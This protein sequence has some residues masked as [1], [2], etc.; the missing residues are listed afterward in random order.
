[1]FSFSLSGY[2]GVCYDRT[3]VTFNTMEDLK[4]VFLKMFNCWH[5]TQREQMPFGIH[6]I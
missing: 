2:A 1:M 6:A 5:K 4:D 3:R